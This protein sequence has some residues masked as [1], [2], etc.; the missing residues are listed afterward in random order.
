MRKSRFSLIELL[1]VIGVIAFLTAIAFP[2]FRL[3]QTAFKKASVRSKINALV[4]AI[5]AYKATYGVFPLR[6][7]M[8]CNSAGSEIA[9][10]KY[11]LI[12][13]TYTPNSPTPKKA[14]GAW[15][16][17][18][19][20]RDNPRNINFLAGDNIDVGTIGTAGK[21]G[22]LFKDYW[23]NGKEV[24]EKDGNDFIVYM[25]VYDYNNQIYLPVNGLTQFAAPVLIYSCGPNGSNDK[26]G[27]D[28][29]CSWKR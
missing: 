5:T 7:E 16:R 27:G 19:L 22:T 25:D 15:L 6:H 12:D 21:L 23:K 24:G 4:M 1:A 11:E 10:V 2:A 14:C 17:D 8:V 28:D 3:G 9:G 13:L 26:G 20:C 18:I 29:I